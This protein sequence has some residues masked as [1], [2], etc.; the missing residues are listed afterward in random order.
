MTSKEQQV[1]W[2]EQIEQLA[3]PPPSQVSVPPSQ[4]LV[5]L[6]QSYGINSDDWDKIED[7]IFR[8][9][10]TQNIDPSLSD[11][12]RKN[13]ANLVQTPMAAGKSGTALTP[14]PAPINPLRYLPGGIN[15]TPPTTASGGRGLSGTT[16][17]QGASGPAGASG[18]TGLTGQTGPA[19]EKGETADNTMMIV[20]VVIIVLVLLSQ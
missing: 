2:K 7:L 3:T 11:A 8:N 18:Q 16:G 12:L 5:N 15:Y 13:V 19:G 9:Q 17:A 10:F 14:S 6:L 1:S 20:G 4:I